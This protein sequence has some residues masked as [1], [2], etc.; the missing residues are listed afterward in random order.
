MTRDLVPDRKSYRFVHRLR[1]RWV[2][3]D[4]QK[5][6]FNGHYLMYLDTA[7]ADY[8][9]ALALPYEAAMHQLGGDLYVKKASLEYH[10]SARYDDQI[11]IGMKCQRIGNS[12]M[13][14][15]AGIFRGDTLLISGEL[16]Y[17]FAN[18]ATQTAQPVPQA[19]REMLTGFEA[20]EPMLRYQMGSWDKLKDQARAVRDEVFLQEQQIPVEMEWDEFDKDAIHA[21]ACNRMGMPVATGRLLAHAPGVGR[22]GRMAVSRVLRGSGLGRGILDLLV[23][24]ACDRGDAQVLLHAQCSAQGFYQSLGFKPRGDIFMEAGIAHIEM[25]K[26]LPARGRAGAA[27]G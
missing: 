5:I 4:M 7:V 18:P 3:V 19:L 11:D 10:G 9:R 12:S 14:F 6:V 27:G 15:V 25:V 13:T 22:I 21:T 1:V 8:W 26:D 17:V 23:Q 20:G 24:A 16:I 2:E